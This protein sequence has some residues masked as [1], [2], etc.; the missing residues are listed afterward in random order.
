[1]CKPRL[2]TKRCHL[3]TIR[4]KWTKLL[5]NRWDIMCVEFWSFQPRT[6]YRCSE[7]SSAAGGDRVY[8]VPFAA[9]AKRLSCMRILWQG[10]AYVRMAEYEGVAKYLE[11]LSHLMRL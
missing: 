9:W 1:M 10:M 2:G 4:S 11:L 3:M 8:Q 7:A 6:Y 5:Y